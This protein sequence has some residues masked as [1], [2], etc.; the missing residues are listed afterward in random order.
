MHVCVQPQDPAWDETATGKEKGGAVW[1]KTKDYVV[2]NFVQKDT[3][4]VR[5]LTAPAMQIA[6]LGR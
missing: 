5:T 6:R 1:G 4:K 2:G 3:V